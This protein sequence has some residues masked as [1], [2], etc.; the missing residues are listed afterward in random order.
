MSKKN[1]KEETENIILDAEVTYGKV[2]QYF[3]ENKKSF[4]IIAAAIIV[5]VG[6]YFAYKNLYIAPMEVEAQS[7]MFMAEKMFE[8]DSL[9]KALNGFA[10]YD[11]FLKIIDNYGGTKSANLA[12]YYAGLCYLNR[13]E[14]QKAIDHLN[15]FSTS[16]LMIGAVAL[17]AT[18]DAYMELGKTSEAA[19]FYEKAAYYNENK[20][21]T[22]IYLMK[23]AAVYEVENKFDKAVTLYKEIKE[24]YEKSK[25]GQEVDRYLAR[26]EAYVK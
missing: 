4:S 16:D 7:R 9:D 5:L 20:F 17:G 12:N 2:E 21:I 24:N 18:G 25:E 15:S 1:Y 26:A 6:G 22:P 11:G 10:E 14:Y 8:A 23:A 13:G 19:S 3:N